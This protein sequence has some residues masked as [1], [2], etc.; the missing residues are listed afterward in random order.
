MS[1]KR[2]P[3][4]AHR[5]PQPREG[6]M[7]ASLLHMLFVTGSVL[8]LP[9]VTGRRAGQQGMEP[10]RGQAECFDR[11][12]GAARGE[13]DTGKD[14]ELTDIGKERADELARMLKDAG[15]THI[16]TTN[17]KRTRATAEPISART[18]VKVEVYDPAKLGEFATRLKSIPGRHLV[19]GHSNT[20]PGLVQA[21]GGDPGSSDAGDRVRPPLRNDTGIEHRH[22]PA[23]LRRR[24]P[25]T[26]GKAQSAKCKGN[27]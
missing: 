16:W 6:V 25:V 17:F 3:L 23:P 9:G 27:Q 22:H 8:L 21:L 20:T 5:S 15:I 18:R 24:R 11:V 13:G 26:A 12:P 1:G 4:T 7:R 14:P 2:S 19:V 10:D